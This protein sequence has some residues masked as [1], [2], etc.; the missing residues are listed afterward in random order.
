MA[1]TKIKIGDVETA[2][3]GIK[4]KISDQKNIIDSYKKNIETL[5]ENWDGQGAQAFM[6]TYNKLSPSI[7]KLLDGINTYNSVIIKF[8][9]D[10]RKTDNYCSSLFKAV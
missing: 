2:A 8:A 3:K 7:K 6:D 4:E 5:G 1:V 10:M 9:D